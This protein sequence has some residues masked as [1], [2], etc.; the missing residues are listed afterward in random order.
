MESLPGWLLKYEEV[1][2]GAY[3]ITII[4][5]SGHKAEVT[6]DDFD[7]YI[8]TVKEFAFDIE[9]QITKNWS[10]FLYELCLTLLQDVKIIEKGYL[11]DSYRSWHIT[12]AHKHILYDGRE[13]FWIINNATG[14][15][16]SCDVIMD[17]RELNYPALRNAVKKYFR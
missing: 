12:A 13:K 15:N 3:K 4:R 16:K 7:L 10:L 11:E 6:G 8:E 1:S 14:D 9:R 17:D 2:N 5:A